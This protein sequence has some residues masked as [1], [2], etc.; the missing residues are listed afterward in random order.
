MRK[1]K[2]VMY[3]FYVENLSKLWQVKD[4][5]D[6]VCYTIKHV[7]RVTKMIVECKDYVLVV[8]YKDSTGYSWSARNAESASDLCMH[9][10]SRI[11]LDN[12]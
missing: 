12:M 2:S 5:I 10:A 1:K 9:G 11:D 4:A 8:R 3:R 7:A 6:Q